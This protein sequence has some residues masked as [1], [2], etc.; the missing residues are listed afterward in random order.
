MISQKSRYGSP[1]RMPSRRS[2]II[3]SFVAVSLL[4]LL[5]TSRRL[6]SWTYDEAYPPHP[7]SDPH[8]SQHAPQGQPNGK[9]Q[10]HDPYDD[11]YPTNYTDV[12]TVHVPQ[13]EPSKLAADPLCEGFPDT[14]KILLVMKTGASESFARVPTQMMTMLRC[15]P[16]YLI[17]SDMAQDIGGEH[18]Y[19][20]L[21]TV[22]PQAMEGNSDFDLYRRQ[23]WCQ[24]DQE[25]C[26]K[27]GNPAKEGWNLDK[28]KNVH[29]AEKTFK[30]RPNYDWYLFVDADTYVLWPGI[31]EWTKKLNPSKKVYLG[32]VTLINNYG[33]GHGGSGYMVSKAAMAQFVGG[34]KK[35]GNKWD[36]RAHN[37]CCGDYIFS[38]ALEKETGVRVQQMWPTINGEK[39]ATLPFGPNHWCHPIVTMHHMNAEEIN[40]FWQ[41]ERKRMVAESRAG[42]PLRPIV[43][44]DIF[45]EFLKPKLT[46]TREDW[47][48]AADN[49][50]Y[51]DL[52]D[53][54][55]KWEDWQINRMKS[56]EKLNDLEKKA[57]LS[58][59][60]CAAACKSVGINEC[61][62]YRYQGGACSFSKAFLLGK[63][64]RKAEHDKDRIYSGWDV[65]KIKKWIG[66][67]KPCDE[68]RWPQVH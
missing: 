35:V 50:Y 24:V 41:F 53:P 3:I 1:T 61:F 28:Y 32:S 36:E 25:N 58:F 38:M 65:D 4:V 21:D 22:L 10:Q 37:E 62:Q 51:L 19:D 49:I 54:K 40:A 14:S 68:I 45:D 42:R 6:G 15:L 11:D 64:V 18:I 26:N 66:E 9:T 56:K 48:N 29:I 63:P 52:S 8:K 2:F 30:M 59:K 46:E 16:D 44:R 20:S 34:D 57:H 31:V 47:D 43:I 27:L 67:Q 39:P 55:H 7:H 12:K 13:D 60:D 5:Y 17:F 33:F 23:K